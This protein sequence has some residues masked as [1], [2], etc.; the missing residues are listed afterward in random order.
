MHPTRNS[1]DTAARIPIS[2]FV[3]AKDEAD[4]IG[5]TIESVRDWLSEVIVIDGGSTD[6][7]PEIADELGAKVLFRAWDGYGPQKRYGEECCRFNWL[8]NLDADEVVTP[9]LRDA[10][11]AL[12]AGGEPPL[13]AYRLPIVEVYPGREAPRPFCY[14]YRVVRLYDRRRVRYSASPVY[15]RVLTGREGVGRLGGRV[16]HFSVRS[17]DD[18]RRKLDSYFHLHL[19][20]K[21][22]PA[23][24]SAC[25]LPFE[26]PRTFLRYY[27]VRRHL[28]GGW[29]GFRLSHVQA[30]ARTRRTLLF[31]RQDFARAKIEGTPSRSD[32]VGGK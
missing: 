1:G 2:C 15:D 19:K 30:A 23:W 31:F 17:L 3:V 13:A 28:M 21:A 14:V 22:V 11:L 24:R 9:E 4:R 32:F 27:V 16:L 29:F 18:Q 26:Y 8:L 20:Q 6:G 10:I 25:R 12:F 7:T 5:R